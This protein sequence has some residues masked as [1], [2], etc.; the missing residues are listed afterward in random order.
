MGLLA[1]L[2]FLTRLPIRLPRAVRPERMLVWFPLAGALIGLLT[3]AAAW[4]AAQA[5]PLP[6]AGAVGVVVGLLI[7]GA[8]HEDG[9]G[10]IADAFGGGWTTERRLEILKDS[11][12]GSYGVAALVS[13]IGLRMLLA[14]SVPDA[15]WLLAGFVATG[16]LGRVAAV[17]VLLWGRPATPT[18][19]AASLIRS[20]H[21]SVIWPLTWWGVLVGV[22]V[23]G[24]AVSLSAA[25]TSVVEPTIPA[26]WPA[27][28]ALWLLLLAVLV[29]LLSALALLRLA[30]VKIGGV[31]GDVMGAAEQVAEIAVWLVI[32]A[33][34]TSG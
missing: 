29:T 6:I 13:S 19:L 8:F 9:L 22:G 32:V 4:V 20:V 12:Q 3:G 31:V 5:L 18:G 21:Q 28:F 11:R 15:G 25:A 2:Q 34:L 27:G 10:D 30:N 14:G 16:A 7:T 24:A 33:V 17:L 1:A 23:A 26:W